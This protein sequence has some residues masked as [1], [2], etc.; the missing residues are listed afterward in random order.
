MTAAGE[1]IYPPLSGMID[2]SESAVKDEIGMPGYL[3]FQK[4]K[5]E[6]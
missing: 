4:R 5:V 6:L 1:E 3:Y 2:K